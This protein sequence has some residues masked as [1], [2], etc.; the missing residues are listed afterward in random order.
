MELEPVVFYQQIYLCLVMRISLMMRTGDQRG[1]F[2]LMMR[3]GDQ[4]YH[5]QNHI[6]FDELRAVNDLAA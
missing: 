6:L 4:R 1:Y 3:T 2:C 5:D